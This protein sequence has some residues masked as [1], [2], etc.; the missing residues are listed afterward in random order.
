MQLNS[1]LFCRDA[2]I[3]S[4][5]NCATSVFAGFVIFSVI[6]HMSRELGIP[7]DQVID[8]GKMRQYN[9][10]LDNIC[11]FLILKYMQQIQ[12][13]LLCIMFNDYQQNVT[14]LS[15]PLK[16]CTLR[17]WSIYQNHDIALKS[18]SKKF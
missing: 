2:F 18:I 13:F 16:V 9:V 6:G 5:G 1:F 12:Y 15:L 14:T 4:V 3:V 17:K 7:V 8:Q 10:S 11:F